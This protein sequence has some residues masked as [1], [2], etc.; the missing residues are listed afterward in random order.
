MKISDSTDL[1]TIEQVATY[2]DMSYQAAWRMTRSPDFPL[3]NIG[4][5]KRFR[6]RLRDLEQWLASRS[7]H[8]TNQREVATTT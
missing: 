7:V 1:L 6:V 4:E 8:N 3:L 2:L 5:K